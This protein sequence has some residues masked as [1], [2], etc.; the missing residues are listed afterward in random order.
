[1]APAYIREM[2]RVDAIYALPTIDRDGNFNLKKHHMLMLLNGTAEEKLAAREFLGPPTPPPLPWYIKKRNKGQT[3]LTVINKNNGERK[4]SL[5]PLQKRKKLNKKEKNFQGYS[6]TNCEWNEALGKYCF[7]PPDYGLD[8]PIKHPL[9][10]ICCKYCFLTPCVLVACEEEI[11]KR[12]AAMSQSCDIDNSRENT[13][14][15]NKQTR[16]ADA[17]RKLVF[18]S[19]M[20]QIFSKAYVK[21]N[22][23]PFCCRFY[24]H[25]LRHGKIPAPPLSAKCPQKPSQLV[26]LSLDTDSD[27]DSQN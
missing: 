26:I 4:V 24:V 6:L 17:M 9:A 25:Q 14:K 23:L 12:E 7:L 21:K 11:K 13:S 16:L 8:V 10:S 22:G 19:L 20:S 3:H 18:P 1:M 15:T 5:S 27:D 2:N